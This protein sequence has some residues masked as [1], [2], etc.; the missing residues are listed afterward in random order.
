MYK[1]ILGPLDGSKLSEQIIP[2]VA[3]E[4]G[5]I[6]K[7][8]MLRVVTMPEIKVPPGVPGEPASPMR[9]EGMLQEYRKEMA[10]A[11]AYLEKQAKLLRDKGLVVECVV[12]QGT[13]G[14]VIVRYTL[15]N[16]IEL[17]A[18]ATHGRTG[19]RRVVFGSTAEYVLRNVGLP[20]LLI[21]PR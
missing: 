7:V 16:Q 13:A 11:P 14:E 20:L 4:A 12:L 19:L 10:E 2:Y 18:L 8:I 1:R 3:E 17:L 6:G 5:C 21:R 9:T 15:A